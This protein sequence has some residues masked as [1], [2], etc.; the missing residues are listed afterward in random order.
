MKKSKN[1]HPSID[2]RSTQKEWGSL[3]ITVDEN[4]IVM[5]G[6]DILISWKKL[7]NKNRIQL[8]VRAPKDVPVRRLESIDSEEH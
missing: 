2:A 3:S 8:W 7:D 1:Q 5:I 4:G 6:D